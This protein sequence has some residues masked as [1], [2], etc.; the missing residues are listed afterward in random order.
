MRGKIANIH[1]IFTDSNKIG[2]MLFW[3]LIYGDC[4]IW[5]SK[6]R[7]FI[8]QSIHCWLSLLETDIG[9]A[10]KIVFL[11]IFEA[12]S[13]LCQLFAIEYFIQ[14]KGAFYHRANSFKSFI[15]IYCIAV[16][17]VLAVCGHLLLGASKIADIIVAN[18]EKEEGIFRKWKG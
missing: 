6:G 18:L 7:L 17:K 8:V 4:C 16:S 11:A 2:V 1:C 3:R 12:K 10:V 15:C 13:F 14:W 5:I 9:W